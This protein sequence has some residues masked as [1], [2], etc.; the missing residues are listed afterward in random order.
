MMFMT[1][2]Y[3]AYVGYSYFYEDFFQKILE[4][5]NEGTLVLIIYCFVLLN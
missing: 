2:I 4:F 1:L 5:A 3:V